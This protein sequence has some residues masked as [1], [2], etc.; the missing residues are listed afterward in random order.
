LSWIVLDIKLQQSGIWTTKDTSTR[1]YPWKNYFLKRFY[2]Q[3]NQVLL[4]KQEAARAFNHLI[5]HIR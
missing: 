5:E 1:L 3:V 2:G 4:R